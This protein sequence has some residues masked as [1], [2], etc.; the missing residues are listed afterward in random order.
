MRSMEGSVFVLTSVRTLIDIRYVSPNNL[1]QHL[2]HSEAPLALQ[3]EKA[4]KEIALDSPS[5]DSILDLSALRER[6]YETAVDV[7][8][9]L[10]TV[11]AI[12]AS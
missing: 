8:L 10:G 11:G 5:A 9:G 3:P 7:A 4:D 1:F 2:A 12:I 6:L